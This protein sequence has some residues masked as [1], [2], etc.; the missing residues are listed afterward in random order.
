MAEA[1]QSVNEEQDAIPSGCSRYTVSLSKPLGLVLEEDPKAGTIKIAEIVDGGNADKDG[2]VRVGDML[3]ATNGMT[4]MGPEQ[5]YGEIKVQTG[6]TFVRLQARGER[7]ETIMA[8]IGSIPG[9][10]KVEL[11]FQ[12]C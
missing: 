5:I 9:N 10:M 3:I 12:R 1:S 7:F 2:Q 8:A 4:R 11:E 6:E